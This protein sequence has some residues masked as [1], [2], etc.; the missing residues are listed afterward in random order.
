MLELQGLRCGY[1]QMEAVHGIDLQ[2]PA[3]R[4][5]A[6]LGPNGA[7]K[8]STMM[9]I[10]GRVSVFAGRIVFDGEDITALPPA[11]RTRRGIAIAPEGRRLFHDLTVAENLTVGG[12]TRSLAD[13]RRAEE[14]VLALFPRLAERRSQRAGSMSGGE[15]QMLAIGRAL[16]AQPRLLLID[17]LSLGLMPAV[18][19]L[20]FQALRELQQ[21]GMTVLLVEQ[22]IQRALRDA[23]HVAV[24]TAGQVAFRGT[25]DEARQHPGFAELFL[26]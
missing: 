21:G 23:A 9:A 26:G 7:G 25:A 12:Y 24:L 8:T 18:V 19:H 1:G 2:V 22:N 14:R 10:V 6:L 20:I 5:T 3:G 4:I 15:Q 11:E 17:E 16:M 13:A